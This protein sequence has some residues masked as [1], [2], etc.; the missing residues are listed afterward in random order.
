MDRDAHGLPRPQWLL[1]PR[2]VA[3]AENGDVYLTDGAGRIDT[4]R[5]KAARLVAFST[6]EPPVDPSELELFPLH[7]DYLVAVFCEYLA[8]N[9]WVDIGEWLALMAHVLKGTSAGGRA[10]DVEHAAILRAAVSPS[11]N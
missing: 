5:R 11:V 4:R 8:Q 7:R 3:L 1:D 2:Q 10:E 9:V 6:L